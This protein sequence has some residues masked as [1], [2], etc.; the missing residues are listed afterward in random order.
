MKPTQTAIRR[1]VISVSVV[2]R[3]ELSIIKIDFPSVS[4][5]IEHI[6]PMFKVYSLYIFPSPICG[7]VPAITNLTTSAVIQYPVIHVYSNKYL[8]GIPAFIYVK[9]S[10][11]D[12]FVGMFG[13]IYRRPTFLLPYSSSNIA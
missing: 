6:T 2:K 9:S 11:P 13:S 8:E 10:F 12:N 4:L 3:Q 5:N 1:I 7:L